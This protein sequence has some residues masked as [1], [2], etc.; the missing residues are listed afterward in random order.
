[1]TDHCPKLNSRHGTAFSLADGSVK[2]EWCPNMPS[3]P[4]VG[5]VGAASTPLPVF[6][7]RVA[8]DGGIEVLV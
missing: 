8:E 6:E 4:F 3:L 2:G 1:M 7:S 5:K